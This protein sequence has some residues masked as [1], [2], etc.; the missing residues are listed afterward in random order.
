MSVPTTS[1]SALNLEEA[2]RALSAGELV[3]LP[4]AGAYVLACDA[5]DPHAVERV[6]TLKDRPFGKPLPLLFSD[7]EAV[8]RA[9]VET[10]LLSLARDFWP[11]PL[12]LSVPA[13]PGLPSSVTQGVHMV[14]IRVPEA[15]ALRM[16]LRS[17]GRP[18]VATS[19]NPSGQPAALTLEECERYRFEGVTGYLESPLGARKRS[20]VVGL[21]DGRLVCY[22]EGSYSQ[23]SVEEAWLSR[24]MT[25]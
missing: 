19:A 5:S 20:T 12:T 13:F 14:G 23:E 11:G 1:Y 6:S 4:L 25:H 21:I 15:E 10:P 8:Q 17:L 9:Q 24:R 7:F 2:K 18:I 3:L 22:R 16:L